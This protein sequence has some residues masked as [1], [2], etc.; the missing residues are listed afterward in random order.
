MVFNLNHLIFHDPEKL[1]ILVGNLIQ[2][3]FHEILEFSSWFNEFQLIHSL[4]HVT[5]SCVLLFFL[6]FKVMPGCL[7]CFCILNS[8]SIAA[9]DII[10][11]A[12]PSYGSHITP[13]QNSLQ[14]IR[15]FMFTYNEIN[16]FQSLC[17]VC[18]N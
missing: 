10:P 15:T 3:V 8:N 2:S 16:W 14:G 17:A 18:T 12:T 4:H 6:D 11:F 13:P 1:L 7:L 5:Y 9:N